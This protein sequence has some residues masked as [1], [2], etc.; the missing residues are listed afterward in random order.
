MVVHSTDAWWQ[1][2]V[3]YLTRRPQGKETKL[4][5]KICCLGVLL[6]TYRRKCTERGREENFLCPKVFMNPNLF[7]I[8]SRLLIL[9]LRCRTNDLS[10]CSN[11]VK[12]N[13]FI[14]RV[15]D[16]CMTTASVFPNLCIIADS[17][18]WPK[19]F[20]WIEPLLNLRILFKIGSTSIW[21]GFIWLISKLA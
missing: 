15:S 11:L 3:H 10:W 13:Q 2:K 18:I 16:T 5:M 4:Y 14:K 7:S 9:W 21:L 17:D 12:R 1:K 19:H 6:E 20:F 8:K